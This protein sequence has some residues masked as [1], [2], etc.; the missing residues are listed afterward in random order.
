M[1]KGVEDLDLENISESIAVAFTCDFVMMLGKSNRPSYE[2]ERLYKILKNRH[3]GNIDQTGKLL[4]SM[5]TLKIF[6]ESEE[7]KWFKYLESMDEPYEIISYDKE[8]KKELAPD[9]DL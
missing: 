7:K 2:Q 8:E 4:W 1:S 9:D 3:G 5:K 6:D